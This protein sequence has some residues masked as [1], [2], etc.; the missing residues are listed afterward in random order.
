MLTFRDGY[1]SF[2][3]GGDV[4]KTKTNYNFNVG[5]SNPRG[6]NLIHE[7]GKELK[8]NIKQKRRRSNKDKSH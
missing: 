5:L 6:Q 3:K 1:K 4:S 8:F 2:I 7:F